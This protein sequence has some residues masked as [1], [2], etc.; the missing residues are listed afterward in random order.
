MAANEEFRSVINWRWF[1]VFGSFLAFFIADGWSFTF[2]ILFPTLVEEFK[3]SRGI[4]SYVPTLLYGIPMILSNL[5]CSAVP[6]IGCKTL[7]IFGGLVICFS[8]ILASIS[9]SLWGLL[10]SVG[11]LT[12]IALVAI[13]ISAYVAVTYWFD[14]STRGLATGIAVAG[15]GLGSVLFPHLMEWLTELYFWRGMV[16]IMAGVCLHATISGC[17]YRPPPVPLNFQIEKNQDFALV[18]PFSQ[19]IAGEESNIALKENQSKEALDFKTILKSSIPQ[20]SLL[21]H[22]LFALYC[23]GNFI[24][25]LWVSIPFLYLYDFSVEVLK[26]PVEQATWLFSVV[27]LARTLGQ[28]ILGLIVDRLKLSPNLV[29]AISVF[30]CGKFTII[31]IIKFTIQTKFK[32][33]FSS[34]FSLLHSVCNKLCSDLSCCD[35]FWF[36]ILIYV[37]SSHDVYG[38]TD[39]LR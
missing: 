8:L 11:V 29:L 33:L 12:S 19:E 18:S 9:T 1:V 15:S 10:F 13:Y 36:I 4:T 20:V 34:S 22:K 38:R 37:R 6:K 28:I 24:L 16:L 3:E 32:T 35:F 14:D 26:L 31:T 2:P 5:A 27:G 25:Y 30:V 23:V 39:R 7:G 17:L 21:K